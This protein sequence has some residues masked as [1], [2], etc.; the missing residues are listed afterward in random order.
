MIN[1]P[2]PTLSLRERIVGIDQEI[3]LL[4]G[5]RVPYINLDN[6]ASTPSF[7]DV[8]RAIERFLPYLLQRPPGHRLQVTAEHGGL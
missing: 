6:A 4:D 8:W 7:V 5:R 2:T 3:P 1:T